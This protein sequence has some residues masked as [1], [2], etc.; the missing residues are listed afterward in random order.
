MTALASPGPWGENILKNVYYYFARIQKNAHLKNKNFSAGNPESNRFGTPRFLN[1]REMV[2]CL[3]SIFE[4]TINPS[5]NDGRVCPVVLLGHAVDNDVEKIQ[6][7]LHFDPR[8]VVKQIDTQVIARDV[9]HWNHRVNQIG[10]QRLV[11]DMGFAFRD[12]HTA[13]NDAA[14]TTIAAVQLI[15]N[16]SHKSISQPCTLQKVVDAAELRSQREYW[17]HGSDKYCFRC[18]S[19]KHFVETGGKNGARCSQDVFCEFCY[20]NRYEAGAHHGHRTEACVM[21]AFETS[22]SSRQG[23]RKRPRGGQKAANYTQAVTQGAQ[24]AA[25][26]NANDI[27]P[28]SFGGSPL[29]TATQHPVQG[30]SAPQPPSTI[31]YRP[32]QPR[33]VPSQD[34]RVSAP[35]WATV[36]SQTPRTGNALSQNPRAAATQTMASSSSVVRSGNIYDVLNGTV[37]DIEK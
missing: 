32:P 24:D 27:P 20:E 7:L 11:G 2:E 10:L 1:D 28:F 15:L 34:P 4:W 8:T 18:G 29:N 31:S 6:K 17:T 3:T 30:G 9:G 35:Q 12:A 16:P 21:K 22:N 19:R 36:A 33:L 5:A 14:Y 37:K 23:R 26:D 13:S 25:A